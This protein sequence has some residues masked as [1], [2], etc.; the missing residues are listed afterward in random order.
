MSLKNF[1]DNIEDPKKTFREMLMEACGV[2][3][4][5]VYRWIKGKSE[6]SKLEKEAISKVA[7][8]PVDKLFPETNEVKE[9][10]NV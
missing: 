3:Q 2:G 7:G 6:P 4:A 10:Q 1:Y 9:V 5:T 8:I